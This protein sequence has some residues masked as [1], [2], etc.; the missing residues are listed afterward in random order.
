MVGSNIHFLYKTA[1]GWPYIGFTIF[2]KVCG[3]YLQALH[4][5]YLDDPQCQ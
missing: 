3:V 5:G 4:R 1:T 2:E